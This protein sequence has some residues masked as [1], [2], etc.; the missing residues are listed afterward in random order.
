MLLR[1]FTFLIIISISFSQI[2]ISYY[3][4]AMGKNGAVAGDIGTLAGLDFNPASLSQL[5]NI[6][7]SANYSKPFI[8]NKFNS[9]SILSAIPLKNTFFI[10][11]GIRTFSF[12]EYR[13]IDASLLYSQQIAKS[14]SLGIQAHY[15]NVNIS[16]FA[17]YKTIY[18]DIG[19]VIDAKNGFFV[20]AFA[21]NVN[22][23]RIENN[24]LYPL[25]TILSLGIAY[26]PSEKAR[27][28]IDLEKSLQY[29]LNIKIGANYLPVKQ[30]N[31][32]VGGQTNPASVSLG[33]QLNIKTISCILSFGYYSNTI[34]ITPYS[35]VEMNIKPPT[36]ETQEK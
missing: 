24:N 2:G 29:P 9:V 26:V 31:I 22:N 12:A 34:G 21:K 35:S 32:Y 11:S 15:Y 14:V 5:K 19:T 30:F 20:G 36:P 3:A 7:I 27:F 6:K 16:N 4:P 17:N 18:L 33:V 1:T 25:P 8:I 28:N 13:E 10:G 23:A